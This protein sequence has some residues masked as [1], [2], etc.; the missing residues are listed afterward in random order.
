[1]K[2]VWAVCAYFNFTKSRARFKN[3]QIFKKN[4]RDHSVKIAAIEFSPSGEFE[5]NKH[6]ADLLIQ[7][8]DGDIMWQKERLLNIGIDSIP[9]NTDIVMLIDCDVIFSDKNAIEYIVKELEG[10]LAVQC[11]SHVCH[12]TDLSQEQENI[13]FLDSAKINKQMFLESPVPG[14]VYLHESIGNFNGGLSGYAWAF[15][16]DII[17]NIKMFDHNIIG[18][19]DRVSA[20]AFMEL[21]I[22]QHIIAGVNYSE[23]L[24]YFN[25]VR[26]MGLKAKDVGFVNMTIYD[27]YHG[28]YEDRRYMQRHDILKSAFFDSKKDLIIGNSLP[29][30]FSNTVTEK[31]KKDIISYFYSRN[32]K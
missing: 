9:D 25:K 8:S 19:G 24:E 5:L 26:K 21:P 10:K 13:D 29:L 2:N 23:Y 28:S 17:K 16:Y 6:D 1:M 30:K 3:Y 14:C 15:R 7:T 12:L 18:S 11:F 22:F 31:L 27:L 32:E 20:A 4:L